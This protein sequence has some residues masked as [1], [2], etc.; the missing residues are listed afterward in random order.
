MGWISAHDMTLQG[1]PAFG[2]AVPIGGFGLN[3]PGYAKTAKTA[4]SGGGHGVEGAVY[5]LTPR[6]LFGYRKSYPDLMTTEK[7]II[8]SPHE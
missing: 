7:S 3:F 5:E 4:E 6:A 1:R 8:V 2:V